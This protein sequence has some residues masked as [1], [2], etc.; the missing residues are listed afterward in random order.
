MKFGPSTF[1]A[2]RVIYSATPLY[3]L[4][5]FL[6]RRPLPRSHDFT[7]SRIFFWISKKF[8]AS[9]IAKSSP[10]SRF[11][12]NLLYQPLKNKKITPK[13]DQKNYIHQSLTDKYKFYRESVHKSNSQIMQPRSWTL[14]FNLTPSAVFIL[15]LS[16]VSFIFFLL[17]LKRLMSSL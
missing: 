2:P 16:Q 15:L 4:F 9:K 11:T 5:W 7:F 3:G 17:P 8:G 13:K 10:F 14:L 6:E 1:R 12:Q